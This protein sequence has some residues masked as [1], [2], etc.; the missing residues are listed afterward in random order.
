MNRNL[1]LMISTVFGKSTSKSSEYARRIESL[2]RHGG[3]VDFIFAWA[4]ER[5]VIRQEIIPR[6]AVILPGDPLER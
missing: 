3:A 5:A 2:T 1:S 4:L 6:Y